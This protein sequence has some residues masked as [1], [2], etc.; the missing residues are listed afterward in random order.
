M[1]AAAPTTPEQIEAAL[2]AFF[3]STP[4]GVACA[5]LYGSQARG[6]ARSDSD[7]DVGVIFLTPAPDGLAG[8]PLDLEGALERVLR[9]PVQVVDVERA[10]ADLVHRILRDG[11]LVFEADRSRRISVEVRRRNEYFDLLPILQRYRA[12]R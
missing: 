4:S 9:R 10:P 3:A 5:Y 11:I 6:T 7:V 2:R 12:A 1:S 8:L